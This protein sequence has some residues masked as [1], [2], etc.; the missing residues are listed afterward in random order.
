MAC[1]EELRALAREA[2]KAQEGFSSWFSS[3]WGRNEAKAAA[4]RALGNGASPEE[5]LSAFRTACSG[6][7]S[8]G[9]HAM[10]ALR[11]L[12]SAGAF[13][14]PELLT[15][16]AQV[17]DSQAE[18]PDN[19]GLRAMQL[20]LSILAV[21]FSPP[22]EAC[23]WCISA[24]AR[25]LGN[26]KGGEGARSAASGALR[27]GVSLIFERCDSGPESAAGLLSC[28]RDWA[29]GRE[30]TWLS[31]LRKAQDGERE[32]GWGKERERALAVL[33]RG[34]AMEQLE[35]AI[36]A[37]GSLIRDQ[38]LL[39]VEV[40]K[41]VSEDIAS[42]VWGGEFRVHPQMEAN[43]VSLVASVL[44]LV[45]GDSQFNM[46]LHLIAR[47]LIR[48]ASSGSI[49]GL[50]ALRNV[51]KD[52]HAACQLDGS[53]FGDG[54]LSVFRERQA[55]LSASKER[56]PNLALSA[57]R[58]LAK[59]CRAAYE[60]LHSNSN[61]D[62]SEEAVATLVE[63]S[64]RSCLQLLAAGVC[65]WLKLGERGQ[66]CECLRGLENMAVAAGMAGCE[67]GRDA[68]LAALAH[69]SLAP[70]PIPGEPSE[71]PLGVG[72]G[73]PL[74]HALHGLGRQHH[75]RNYEQ[76]EEKR[77]PLNAF[78]LAAYAALLGV[79]ETLGERTDSGWALVLEAC[80]EVK[81]SARRQGGGGG[82]ASEEEGDAPLDDPLLGEA[83]RMTGT[84]RAEALLRGTDDYSEVG[85]GAVLSSLKHVATREMREAASASGD[86]PAAGRGTAREVISLRL[87]VDIVAANARRVEQ[88][89]DLGARERLHTALGN[90]HAGVRAE[91]LSCL[92]WCVFRLMEAGEALERCQ[93]SLSIQAFCVKE[94]RRVVASKALPGGSRQGA[95]RVLQDV[96]QARGERLGEDGWREALS[97]LEAAP[98]EAGDVDGAAQAAFSGVELVVQ[99]YL[100]W[101]TPDLVAA[102]ARAAEVHCRWQP[103]LNAALNAVGLLWNAADHAAGRGEV[104]CDGVVSGVLRSLHGL[105]LDSRPE[106]RHASCRAL[107]SALVSHGHALS[108]E[109][110]REA[111]MSL[112]F[113][114]PLQVEAYIESLPLSSTDETETPAHHEAPLHH[115]RDTARKQW[116][117]TASY[118]LAACCRVAKAHFARLAAEP[119]FEEAWEEFCCCCERS[120]EWAHDTPSSLAGAL[121]ACAHA[122]G[123]G[124]APPRL[125]DRGVDGLGRMAANTASPRARSDLAGACQRFHASSRSQLDQH[126]VSLLVAAEEGIALRP[127]SKAGN[128]P[129]SLLASAQ[130]AAF[131]A[132]PAFPPFEKEPRESWE[133][134]LGDLLALSRGDAQVLRALPLLSRFGDISNE[135]HDECTELAGAHP[136]ALEALLLAYRRHAPTWARAAFLA[137]AA[138]VASTAPSQGEERA[139]PR[140]GGASHL[141]ALVV[142]GLPAANTSEECNHREVFSA[143]AQAYE[144]FLG[145][146]PRLVKDAARALDSLADDCLGACGEATDGE[147][148][149]LV[150]AVS[151]AAD[152]ENPGHLRR[153]ALRK[154]AALAERGACQERSHT[155]YL[156]A[157]LEAVPQL[158]RR[159]RE[160]WRAFLAAQPQSD[161]RLQ[162][163]SDALAA[164]EALASSPVPAEQVA[165][166]ASE[167]EGV[168]QAVALAGKASEP[169]FAHLLAL[170]SHLVSLIVA[171]EGSV[172]DSAAHLLSLAGDYLRLPGCSSLTNEH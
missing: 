109:S 146:A 8:L 92:E 57:C 18:A 59:S 160:A 64:W 38:R 135:L 157:S 43:L 23:R 68:L 81:R 94:L 126:H 3:S 150:G 161:V 108:P 164:M 115:T 75:P 35:H 33:P 76:E 138:A 45:S 87:L 56:L 111:S 125:L 71:G 4:E 96:L 167:R 48:S 31:G 134:L 93:G 51:L 172:R 170:H 89:W 122:V 73:G 86:A 165:I 52:A 105:A 28:L 151:R 13:A 65:A 142:A 147:I 70:G 110:W 121:S 129:R 141:A 10:E 36:H 97:A 84:E 46:S 107:A 162:W 47:A 163:A 103:D 132:L 27:Q 9:A 88:A 14:E 99:D 67:D 98:E 12:V 63:R 171:P 54:L 53:E 120:A 29:C 130:A 60:T 101:L 104:G 148:A 55:E 66:A 42:Y 152:G 25:P 83:E 20:A 41:L 156:R 82:R 32:K 77:D 72:A 124:R 149:R 154:L 85:L 80:A 102:A 137:P 145:E 58:E 37:H 74:A 44:L 100:N 131:E 143:L 119:R 6:K 7:Q 153:Q 140:E 123:R 69:F 30:A 113:S 34:E 17:A 91:G 22:E 112:C 2:S 114:L 128:E 166:P 118:A 79:A 40:E 168:P 39:A 106:V 90:A 26:A 139:M 127:G 78:N 117:E 62:A 1:A 16:A 24:L 159:S 11:R 21:D 133:L 15:K 158:L 61:V 144:G 155:A 19:R 95:L 116:A 169:G 5:T 50:H 49:P 136:R